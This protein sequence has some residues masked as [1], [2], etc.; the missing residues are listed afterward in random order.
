MIESIHFQGKT[1]TL[2]EF[3]VFQREHPE[4]FQPPAI[5]TPLAKLKEVKFSE[6]ESA[7]MADQRDGVLTSIG[8]KMAYEDKDIAAVDGITRFAE[9]RQLEKI[10]LIVTADN[11]QY[12]NRFS[13]AQGYV[14]VEEMFEAKLNAYKKLKTLIYQVMVA[15]TEDEINLIAWK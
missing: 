4:L 7:C 10:P 5:V 13:P 3:E 15:T 2:E 6:F 12:E 9:R 8:I 11:I 14:L 1:Y